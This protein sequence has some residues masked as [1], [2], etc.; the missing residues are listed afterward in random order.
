MAQI[1]CHDPF[2]HKVEP[3]ELAS[4]RDIQRLPLSGI[5][6]A[7]CRT[8]RV[9]QLRR[10]IDHA[11]ASAGR[12]LHNVAGVRRDPRRTRP[13]A[14]QS[15][16]VIHDIRPRDGAVGN[17]LNAARRVCVPVDGH[18]AEDVLSRVGEV[19]V[20]PGGLDPVDTEVGPGGGPHRLQQ[21]R[22]KCDAVGSRDQVDT[23]HR[24]QSRVGGEEEP[25]VAWVPDYAVEDGRVL[26][27]GNEPHHRAG[28][29]QVDS[30]DGQR[31]ELC[32]RGCQIPRP[33]D[34]GEDV[35]GNL[36]NAREPAR[37]REGVDDRCLRAGGFGV[38]G[39]EIRDAHRRNHEAA[40]GS[41]G[42]VLDE[43]VVGESIDIS[44]GRVPGATTTTDCLCSAGRSEES[45]GIDAESHCE[46]KSRAG[47][48]SDGGSA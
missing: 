1:D 13:L 11:L 29:V 9:E 48:K 36:G 10:V 47:D 28:G 33:R 2:I 21:R 18:P 8:R 20:G 17:D 32:S 41:N 7:Q 42:N 19:D 37:V 35:G 45:A 4:V 16:V 25:G 31:S 30:P 40:V 14:A 44:D 34:H 22:R 26:D 23:P 24:T 43:R 6:P 27:L 12:H 15:E 3:N 46:L 39:E 38:D 5:T